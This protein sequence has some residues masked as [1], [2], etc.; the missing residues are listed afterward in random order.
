M[1][2]SDAVIEAARNGDAARLRELLTE[3]PQ[4]VNARNA[5]GETPILAALYRRHHDAVRLLLAANPRL[6]IFE[7][8]AAGR[9]E[10]VRQL[11]TR[12]PSLAHACA[13]DGFHPLGLACYFGHAE[14]A[15]FL[16]DEG[17]DVNAPSENAIEVRPINAAAAARSVKIAASL[18]ARGADPNARQ[19]SGFTP[20]HTAAK[21]GD[22]E[23]LKLLLA[24]GANARAANGKGETPAAL[25]RESGHHDIAAL[26]DGR[27]AGA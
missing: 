16:M 19:Q 4:L 21:N 7:A 5:A 27:A 22:A 11:V 3:D 1:T 15:E 14:L 8:A 25:A 18:L 20:L 13:P 12:N 9:L 2:R 10:R 24:Y 6:D 23:L 26:L 17:A